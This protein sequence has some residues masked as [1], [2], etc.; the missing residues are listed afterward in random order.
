MNTTN[1]IKAHL[2]MILAKELKEDKI[3]KNPSL[4]IRKLESK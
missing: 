1:D 4:E 2:T 3:N